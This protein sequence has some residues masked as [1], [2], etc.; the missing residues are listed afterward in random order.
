MIRRVCVLH[1]EAELGLLAELGLQTY[2]YYSSHLDR[3]S[4]LSVLNS[5][6]R[7]ATELILTDTDSE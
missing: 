2:S 5:S 3:R 6:Y 4:R 7:T 1:L